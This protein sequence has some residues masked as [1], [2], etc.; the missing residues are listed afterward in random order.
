M[1]VLVPVRMRMRVGM[2]VLAAVV[3]MR[4]LVRMSVRVFVMVIVGMIVVVTMIVRMRMIVIV[5]VVMSG[6]HRRSLAFS[7][8]LF[9]LVRIKGARMEPHGHHAMYRHRGTE[10]IADVHDHDPCGAGREHREK[11]GKSAKSRA[12][13]NV[14]WDSNDWG[15]N[16]TADDAWQSAFHPGAH[17]GC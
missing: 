2:R 1:R 6:M 5:I 15:G 11:G 12:V 10:T 13:S 3:R 7:W 9:C 8:K 17:D 14:R 16:D 4:V